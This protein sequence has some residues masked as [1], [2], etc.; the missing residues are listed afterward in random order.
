MIQMM[1]R[2]MQAAVIRRLFFCNGRRVIVEIYQNPQSAPKERA[3]DLLGRM[4]AA[5]KLAQLCGVFAIPGMEERTAK[6][7]PNGVG[8][9]STLEFR[10]IENIHD[11]AAWQRR[12]QEIVLKNSRFGIPAVFHMEGLCGPLMAGG[13]SFPSGIARG[14]S[15]HPET[16][17]EIGESVARQELAAGITQVLAPVLDISRDPRMGRYCEPYS[18]DGTLAAEMGAAYTKGIQNTEVDGRKADAC[19]KHFLGFHSSQGG[20]HGTNSELGD[21]VIL[22]QFGKPFQAAIQEGLKG[23]MPCYNTINGMPVHASQNM[24]TDL[25]R[26]KMGFEGVVLSDYSAAENV[27][28]VQNLC[29]TE[30]DT[31]YLCMNA[32]L[33]VELPMPHMFAGKLAE[34]FESGDRNMAVLDQACLRVLEA[35]FRMGLFE[36][37][38][39]MAD[40]LLDRAYPEQEK[41]REVT[42]RS[43]REGLVLLKN[44]GTLPLKKGIRKIAVIGPHAKNARFFFGGYT[45]VSMVEAAR[46]A[47]NSMA[48]T[49]GSGATAEMKMQRIP[50]TNVQNDDTPEFASILPWLKPECKSLWEELKERLP[51]VEF[52][53][54]K[55]YEIFGEDESGHAEALET[56]R[57]ADMVILTLGGKNGS[58]SVA[59]MGEGVDGTDINLCPSQERFIRKAAQTGKPLVGVRRVIVSKSKEKDAEM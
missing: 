52:V 13:V 17:Q 56:A 19:A 57:N 43:A 12:L 21:L 30:E 28:M 34:Q 51:D 3:E 25:L 39:A 37:P 15:F 4:T 54:A 1:K 11:A 59:T 58:G 18:E 49:G 27:H 9:I 35:K 45:H 53:Y 6:F 24:L 38:F 42:L 8:Q 41:D 29:E 46:A 2:M 44:D 48:G 32:G 26:D 10:T 23:V 55:G 36:H 40:D 7:I 22:E 16:E 5:E 31:G 47:A 33:D 14:S 50:G 20:I